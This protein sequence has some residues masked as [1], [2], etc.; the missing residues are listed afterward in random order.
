ML[1]N[2]DQENSR[3]FVQETQTAGDV[4]RPFRHPRGNVSGGHP[5]RR[6][7]WGVAT[8]DGTAARETASDRAAGMID[9]S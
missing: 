7:W 5:C 3:A 6:R 8:G 4:V 2:N 9:H 1:K